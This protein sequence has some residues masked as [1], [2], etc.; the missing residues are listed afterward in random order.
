MWPVGVEQL[1]ATAV[2]REVAALKKHECPQVGEGRW[3]WR[4]G[5]ARV[6]VAVQD[7]RV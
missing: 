5:D 7:T 3:W 6:R 1:K 2:G 4:G